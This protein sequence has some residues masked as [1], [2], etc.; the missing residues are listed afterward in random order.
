MRSRYVE[1]RTDFS[2]PL[3]FWSFTWKSI[4]WKFDK[5]TCLKQFGSFTE[6]VET[7]QIPENLAPNQTLYNL[8]Q[9]VKTVYEKQNS[10]LFCYLDLFEFDKSRNLISMKKTLDREEIC[11]GKIGV[12]SITLKVSIIGKYFLSLKMSMNGVKTYFRCLSGLLQANSG[13]FPWGFK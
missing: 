1:Y 6:M 12:C 13:C 7:L 11:P 8:D 9:Q 10:E 2:K 5:S 4:N 3:G